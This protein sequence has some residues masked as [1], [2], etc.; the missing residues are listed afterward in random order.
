MA[1]TPSKCQTLK[2]LLKLFTIMTLRPKLKLAKKFKCS[3]LKKFNYFL[4]E[5]SQSDDSEKD[6]IPKELNFNDAPIDGP[7]TRVHARFINNKN[8][9]NWHFPF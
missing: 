2:A 4:E 9:V 8:A 7:I 5:K 3:T 1:K 6:T